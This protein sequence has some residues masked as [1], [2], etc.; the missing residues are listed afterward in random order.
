M[1]LEIV[2]AFG[3]IFIAEMGDKSQI[4]AMAFATKYDVKKVLLGIFLGAFLNHSIAVLLG[5]LFNQI[6]PVTAISIIAGLAFILFALWS[7]KL[8]TDDDTV[9]KKVKYGPVI[10]VAIAFFIGELGDKTQLAAITLSASS[11]YPL[12]VLIGTV[13]GMFVTG[14]L[15]IYVGIKLGSKIPDFFMKLGAAFIFF[16]FG[17]IKLYSSIPVELSEPYFTIPFTI[18]IL[19]LGYIIFKPSIELRKQGIPTKLQRTANELHGYYY[20]MASRLEEI[21]LGV[22]VCGVCSGSSC[23]VGYTKM[24]I[25]KAINGEEINLN[26]FEILNN[27]KIF[28]IDKIIESLNLTLDLLKEDPCK[29]DF[30]PIHQARNNFETILLGSYIKEFINLEEYLKKIDKL[31]RSLAKKLKRQN[32]I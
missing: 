6:I 31:D 24:I 14:A 3:F 25:R 7:L 28:D 15:A 10:T 26:Y 13:S 8:N 4:L 1:I 27:S 20:D 18:G 23:L 5:S 16:I 17:F 29:E 9:K 19:L 30:I 2:R 32:R 22:D 21:C 12:Y 11:E